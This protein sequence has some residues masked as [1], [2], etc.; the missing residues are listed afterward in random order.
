[1]CHTSREKQEFTQDEEG[2]VTLCVV[3]FLNLDMCRE[4]RMTCRCSCDSN[5][6]SNRR[7]EKTCRVTDV[8]R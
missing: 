4:C 5:Y 8:T 6:G 3:H 1:M 2:G 7:D